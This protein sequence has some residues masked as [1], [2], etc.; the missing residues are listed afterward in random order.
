[1]TTIDNA[2]ERAAAS[3][4][5][6]TL[7]AMERLVIDLG[8]RTHY[9]SWLDIFPEDITLDAGGGVS[10]DDMQTLAADEAAFTAASKA[11]AAIMLPV[12]EAL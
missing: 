8:K 12:L 3:E 6:R 4:R 5:L 10:R 7:D 11:W 2:R 9:A 1:M